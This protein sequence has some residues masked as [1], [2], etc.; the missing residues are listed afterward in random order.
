MK[1]GSAILAALCVA[2]AA[3]ASS[4]T[5]TFDGYGLSG[6][7]RMSYN[8]SRAWDARGPATFYSVTCGFH[9]FTYGSGSP[10]QTFCAQLFEG[11]TAGN[12]YTFDIVD[13]SNVPDEPGHP[14]NMGAIKAT[15]IQD[16][17]HRYYYGV[18]TAVEASAFQ[19]AIYEIS[20]ENITAADAAGAVAQL[21]L[22]KGAFQ[23]QAAG[24]TGYAD[25]AAM[26]AS[27]GQGGFKT[28]GGALQG[29]TNPTAQDQLLVVPVGAPAI[30]AGLGLLGVGMLRRRK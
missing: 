23:S 4:I 29:L 13:P 28:I 25:A 17:Y 5:L 7:N 2:S 30:L 3:S 11:V 12:T 22:M 8:H 6:Q 1:I 19:L 9:N 18:D 21:S 26:L 27:L 14:G 10:R 24:S 15:L 20:H 16:L